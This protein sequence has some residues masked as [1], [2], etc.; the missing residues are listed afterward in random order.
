MKRIVTLTLALVLL[1]T[2][3][4]VTA[5]ADGTTSLGMKLIGSEGYQ[6]MTSSDDLV[7][8]IKTVEGFS[9]TPYWDYNQYTIGF[10]CNAD[11]KE[12]FIES[13]TAK[14]AEVLLRRELKENY[15]AQVNR[16]CQRIGRQPNQHQFDALVSFTYNCGSGWMGT[17]STVASRIDAWLRNPTTEMEFVSAIGAWKR[18][19]GEILVGL[20]QRRIREAILFL[21]GEY[22][23]R[24]TPDPKWNVSSNLAVI[25]DYALPYYCSVVFEL[26]GGTVDA[27][28]SD[29]KDKDDFVVYYQKGGTYSP[30]PTPT[31]KGCTFAGWKITRVNSNRPNNGDIIN[32]DTVV[33]S[34]LEVTAQ[35]IEGTSGSVDGNLPGT[36]TPPSG[37]TPEDSNS[38]VF[39]P[40]AGQP[41][42]DVPTTAW[43]L[44]SL[45]YVYDNGYMNG[46][47][48][49]IFSPE[50]ALNRAMLVTV[51][52][53]MD[54]SPDVNGYENSFGDVK[55]SAYYYDAVVWAQHN[56]I[57]NGITAGRFAPEDDLTR[58]QAVAI[59]YRYCVEYKDTDGSEL[60]ELDSFPDCDQVQP[61][62]LEPMRWA[63]ANHVLTGVAA[64][65]GNTILDVNGSLRRSQCA[66]LIQRCCTEI[67]G[68]EE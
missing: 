56:G 57:V 25:S 66:A 26:N 7:D 3:F 67:L 11:Q 13:I 4:P 22:S 48:E 18:A 34:N 45:I 61:Y 44:D 17:A 53:R 63:V 5:L 49:E 52:Y 24:S 29:G 20:V 40:A 9:E 35:W 14:E 62:A 59:F 27:A 12:G 51:L 55:E 8:I 28:Y 19:G 33:K 30:L 39:I 54:G 37:N 42:R 47:T 32:T 64:A 2:C 23:I 15:E 68:M 10:G 16:Y 36:V 58:Q 1:M 60:A 50:T 21:K 6:T 38:G 46:I 65:N 43:Y 31:R 41:F